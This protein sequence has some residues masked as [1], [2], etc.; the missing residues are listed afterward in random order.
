[1]KRTL[2][3]LDNL[4]Q[5]IVQLRNVLEQ[6]GTLYSDESMAAFNALR[7]ELEDAESDGQKPLS[8]QMVN[9]YWNLID[10]FRYEPNETVQELLKLNNNYEQD[11]GVADKKLEKSLGSMGYSIYWQDNKDDKAVLQELQL[12]MNEFLQSYNSAGPLKS[13]DALCK[14]GDAITQGLEEQKIS[15]ETAEEILKPLTEIKDNIFNEQLC[16]DKISE[17]NKALQNAL[18]KDGKEKEGLEKSEAAKPQSKSIVEDAAVLGQNIGNAVKNIVHGIKEANQKID[19]NAKAKADE[20]DK[21]QEN[22]LSEEE[23][24]EIN[25]LKE[26]ITKRYEKALGYSE[27]RSEGVEKTAQGNAQVAS[28]LKPL[29]DDLNQDFDKEKFKYDFDKAMD[30]MAQIKPYL[31]SISATFEDVWHDLDKLQQGVD[32]FLSDTKDA[33]EQTI[34]QQR[35][36]SAQ[37]V[38]QSQSDDKR[39]L[40]EELQQQDKVA[41]KQSVKKQEP[42]KTEDKK[43]ADDKRKLPEE[44]V[45]ADGGHLTPSMDSVKKAIQKYTD[46]VERKSFKDT[47]RSF[48][49]L[50]NEINAA[51]KAGVIS[52]DVADELRRPLREVQ[53][54]A[55]SVHLHEDAVKSLNEIV[56]KGQMPQQRPEKAKDIVQ[57]VADD[58]RKLDYE[59]QQQDKIADKQG[60][61]TVMSEPEKTKDPKAKF[62][63]FN[64]GRSVEKDLREEFSGKMQEFID[65]YRK[66]LDG[67]NVGEAN[68]EIDK[69]TKYISSSAR[70]GVI[71]QSMANQYKQL[72]S[73]Q[74]GKSEHDKDKFIADFKAIGKKR[75]EKIEQQR[76][77]TAKDIVQSPA[78]N[79]REFEEELREAQQIGMISKPVAKLYKGVYN[80]VEK[81]VNFDERLGRAVDK[82]HNKK[83]ENSVEISKEKT[84]KFKDGI[85]NVLNKRDAERAAHEQ[86]KKENKEKQEKLF[87]KKMFGKG[88]IND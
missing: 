24:K 45:K 21:R 66:A 72:L 1:M 37:D 83:V 42:Q 25:K 84:N 53:S 32:D 15:R 22:N 30:E 12:Q 9:Q 49:E 80:A 2:E 41:D 14:V 13:V 6:E 62:G 43:P 76:D 88:I 44:Q 16:N 17:F 3:V 31:E 55:F 64:M 87:I 40:P 23:I 36:M 51:A 39:K 59:M 82:E 28:I 5:R 78:D 50:A 8:K 18:S 75:E 81:V 65:N 35:E 79:K 34:V 77:M 57:S 10:R 38:V 4:H 74:Y 69:F 71:S 54:G 26:N 68:Y 7:F 29:V 73:G 67:E 60:K 63:M 20:Y 85:I 27:M 48:V 46:A 47:S 11:V 52:N 58:K 33:K 19:A 70:D 61:K 56:N 86:E